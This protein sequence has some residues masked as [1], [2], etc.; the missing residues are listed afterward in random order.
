MEGIIMTDLAL[1][2]AIG[3]PI[4]PASKPNLDKVSTR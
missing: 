2:Q 4:Q 1:N 3:G